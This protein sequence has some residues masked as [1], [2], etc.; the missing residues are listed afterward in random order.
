MMFLGSGLLVLVLAAE[1]LA[2]TEPL[3]IVDPALPQ[4]HIG[5]IGAAAAVDPDEPLYASPTRRDRIGRIIAPVM[6]NGQG[7][8]RFVVDTGATHSA[9][10]ERLAKQLGLSIDP[11]EKVRLRGVTGSALVASTKVERFQ[12]GDL[13]IENGSVPVLASVWSGADGVLGMHGLED[14]IIVVDFKRDRIQILNS[15]SKRWRDLTSVPIKLGFDR[16]LLAD[17]NVGRVRVKAII[18]TGAQHTL[19]NRAL[20]EALEIDAGSRIPTFISVQGVTTGVQIGELAAAPL[21]RIG[22]M[23]MAQVNVAFGDMHVFDIWGL[24]EEPALLVGMDVL[25]VLE[26][27][28]IDYRRRELRFKPRTSGITLRSR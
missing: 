11:T 23:H 28:V 24:A 6:I 1:A 10:S 22:N 17:A 25:G 3:P 12:A 26:V 9:V 7:P 15:S 19:G 2:G 20:R 8:F 14:K 13:L 18:D 27:I 5:D 21:I 4:S 16:L